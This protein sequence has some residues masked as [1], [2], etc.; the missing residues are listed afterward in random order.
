MITSTL[1]WLFIVGVA[2]A[3]L[4]FGANVPLAWGI[5][6]V[7][8]GLLITLYALD[9]SV[10]GRGW[11]VP[12]RRIGLPAAAFAVV[13][14]WI[15][16]QTQTWVP[17][18]LKAPAW[19]RASELLGE[20]LS[21]TISVNPGETRLALIRLLTALAVFLLAL[22]LGRESRW[23]LRIVGAIAVAG[24]IHA[25]Y[26]LALA[27]AGPE[28]AAYLLP[29]SLFKLKQEPELTGTFIN[30][31]HFAIY[32]GLCL[33]CAWG[34]LLREL[35]GSMAD[36]GYDGG[37]EA[38]AKG[39]GLANVVAR[40][41]VVLMPLSSALLWTGSRA[42]FFLT[43]AALLV[44]IFIERRRSHGSSLVMRAAL[45]VAV[46]GIVLGLSTRGDLFG[47]R[48][49]GTSSADV[50]SRLAVAKLTLRAI[51]DEPLLGY[52]YGTFA[53]VFPLYRDDTISLW[54]RWTEAHNCYLEAML[55]LGIP[56]AA[57][58]FLGLGAIVWRCLR[59]ALVR[60]RDRFAP[61][62]A[63]GVSLIVASHAL[64]DFSI[65]LQGIAL[66]YAA[67]I[68]AGYAQSWSSQ[69]A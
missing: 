11:P 5:N 40:Y 44:T 35:R 51:A 4:I 2:L 46:A 37:R 61:S 43:V 58:L 10:A 31:N 7:L 26:A 49:A 20:S 25:V 52:G 21:G 64:V 39:L 55:G 65:Q 59:G 34:L 27:A 30:R 63:V 29:P 53:S 12:L 36:Q 47:A 42:G 54:G 3:P 69:D 24:A 62:V 15:V 66:T 9:R 50:E 22:E 57:A 32:L 18:A 8:F 38:I 6:A 23:A 48:L 17:D 60:K 45:A 16:L 33:V 19:A 14:V 41:G 1:G 67:L 56:A 68:G 28:A 13:V